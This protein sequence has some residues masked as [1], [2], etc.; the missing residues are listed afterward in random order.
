M[1]ALEKIGFR[2]V[3]ILYTDVSKVG[4]TIPELVSDTIANLD[5][6]NRSMQKVANCLYGSQDYAIIAMK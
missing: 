5:E 2:K 3:E 6:F 1:N 4:E